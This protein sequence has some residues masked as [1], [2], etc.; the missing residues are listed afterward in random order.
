MSDLKLKSGKSLYFLL[1]FSLLSFVGCSSRTGIDGKN[2][3]HSFPSPATSPLVIRTKDPVPA[4]VSA[5][6]FFANSEKDPEDLNPE[7]TYP[8]EISIEAEKEDEMIRKLLQQLINGPPAPYKKQG[9]YTSLP[10]DTRINFVKVKGDIVQVDFG[11]SLNSGGGSCMMDQR[12][13]QIENTLLHIPGKAVKKVV[14]SVNGDTQNV[15][16]P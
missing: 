8:I 14:I 12:R 13:S 2:L 1:L 5:K 16:Q 10:K 15:L 11:E 4:K 7:V 3:Q 6:V 9:Y